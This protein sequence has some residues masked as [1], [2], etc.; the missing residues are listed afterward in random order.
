MGAMLRPQISVFLEMRGLWK[1][2]FMVFV[3][4]EVVQDTLWFV[5]LVVV[6]AFFWF[7]SRARQRTESKQ[8][9]RR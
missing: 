3:I 4:G 5:A 8:T 7:H 6:M 9:H 2:L 1:R